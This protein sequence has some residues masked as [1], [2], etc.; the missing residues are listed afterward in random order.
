MTSK[1]NIMA[2]TDKAEKEVLNQVI[3]E[4]GLVSKAKVIWI[5]Q[6]ILEEIAIKFAGYV[7]QYAVCENGQPL[8]QSVFGEAFSKHKAELDATENNQAAQTIF[9]KTLV[10]RSK[11]VFA[12]QLLA[13]TAQGDVEWNPLVCGATSFIAQFPDAIFT[14]TRVAPKVDASIAVTFMLIKILPTSMLD[15][16]TIAEMFN[17]TPVTALM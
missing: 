8:L 13:S 10:S 14:N 3:R 17:D 7:G 2:S 11:E 1:A 5:M 4:L 12:Q 15:K 6:P 16:E 9:I